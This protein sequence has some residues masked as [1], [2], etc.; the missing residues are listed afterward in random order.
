MKRILI[1]VGNTRT[2]LVFA[3]DVRLIERRQLSTDEIS[4]E[5]ILEV[6]GDWASRADQVVVCSVVPSRTTAL[7]EVF[8]M[9][10][11]FLGPITPIGGSVLII[12]WI[13]LGFKIFKSQ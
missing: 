1:D 11:K 8:G 13:L 10:L 5:S 7:Q 9:S 2:K 12:G 4:R 6:I 3:D